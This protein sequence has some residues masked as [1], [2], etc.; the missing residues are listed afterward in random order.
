MA[1]AAALTL[2]FGLPLAAVA[3]ESSPELHLGDVS[4]RLVTPGGRVAK[5]RTAKGAVTDGSVEND[6][7]HWRESNAWKRIGV[8]G[9]RVGDVAAVNLDVES[10]AAADIVCTGTNDGCIVSGAI[11][12]LVKGDTV[13]LIDSGY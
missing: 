3:G 2:G 13:Q 6:R 9:E 10:K 5:E 11:A 4:L 8:A 12:E 1:G 7:V